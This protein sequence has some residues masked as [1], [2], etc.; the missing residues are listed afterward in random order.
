M[1]LSAFQQA[2]SMHKSGNLTEAKHLYEE[3]LQQMP[4]RPDVLYNLALSLITLGEVDKAKKTLEKVLDKIPG[5]EDALNNLGALLLK[6]DQMEQALQCFSS[7][8]HGN[9]AHLEARNNLAVTL[10]QLGRYYHAI[11]HFQLYLEKM[12]DDISA[13]YSYATALLDFGDFTTAIVEFEKILHVD[14]HH[15][16]AL[17]NLGIAQ[18]KSGQLEKAKENFGKV[19]RQ[20][21]HSPEIAYLYSA[22][23][24]NNIPAVPPRQYI[25]QLFDHYAK[26]Y[27]T[28]MIDS[29]HYQVPQQLRRLLEKNIAPLP[30][31]AWKILDIGC[32]TGL[33]GLP[34]R[35]F[36]QKLTGIDLS[37]KMLSLAKHKLIYDE[38]IEMDILDYLQKTPC[39][40]DLGVAADTF[41]YFGELSGL[42]SAC[43]ETLKPKGYLLF[44]VE[45]SEE[46]THN[47]SLMPHGR[48]CHTLPYLETLA[49]KHHF[50]I[51]AIEES[52]LRVQNQMPVKGLLC[53]FQRRSV[54]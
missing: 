44:S 48:Y 19:L 8:V 15:W 25:Q 49:K 34:F 7:V 29:L 46:I 16:N 43:A 2:V 50:E 18:L 12:P 40:Y 31:R 17:S 26:Y 3:I 30:D 33:S 4:D 23:T 38:L 1:S 27:E 14:P 37:P 54:I 36:S 6:Q 24:Q 13:R 5:H 53:L 21:Q 22:L 10:L 41:N 45:A 35:Q 42:F 11:Q 20:H 51:M 47:W 9:P 39:A 28:H 32:G 52:A